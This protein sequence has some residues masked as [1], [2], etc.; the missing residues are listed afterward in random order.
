MEVI[1]TRVSTA[2]KH[3][4]GEPVK[5]SNGVVLYAKNVIEGNGMYTFV[6]GKGAKKQSITRHCSESQAE[7][8]KQDLEGK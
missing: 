7:R 4:K 5:D 6:Y 8:I 2:K 1:K 3:R